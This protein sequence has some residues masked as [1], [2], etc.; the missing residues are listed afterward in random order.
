MVPGSILVRNFIPV[1]MTPCVFFVIQIQ[2]IVIDTTSGPDPEAE[3]RFFD[4][5]VKNNDKNR[6]SQLHT[7]SP[8]FGSLLGEVYF[9]LEI[10]LAVDCGHKQ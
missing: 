4:I 2:S 10:N 8:T 5:E 3:Y 7:F 9:K 1:V 6:Y